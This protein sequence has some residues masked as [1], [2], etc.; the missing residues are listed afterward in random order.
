MLDV[1][2]YNCVLD[3]CV[4]A[5][6][7]DRAKGLMEEMQAQRVAMSVVTH[8]TLLKGNCHVGEFAQ[9]KAILAEISRGGLRPTT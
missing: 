3:V 9:A 2:V 1:T 5:G 8:N 4:S 6:A 7:I